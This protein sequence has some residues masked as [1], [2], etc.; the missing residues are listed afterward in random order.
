M[1]A[2]ADWRQ[3]AAARALAEAV[4]ATA[5]EA[6][7]ADFDVAV[8]AAE[9]AAEARAPQRFTIKT[10]I[11]GIDSRQ[12]PP[13]FTDAV[14]HPDVVRVV[15]AGRARL[16]F[17][18]LVGVPA[19]PVSASAMAA[20]R[21]MAAIAVRS[22]TEPALPL[23]AAVVERALLGEDWSLGGDDRRALAG[24][25]INLTDLVGALRQDHP[26]MSGSFAA[27]RLPLADLLLTASRLVEAHTSAL[28]R[29]AGAAAALSRL[30]QAVAPEVEVS[31]G[32]V[33]GFADGFDPLSTALPPRALDLRA[34][35]LVQS[36]LRARLIEHPISGRLD[37]PAAGIDAIDFEIRSVGEA[38]GAAASILIGSETSQMHSL[39]IHVAVRAHIGGIAIGHVSEFVLP[40]EVVI[41]A[42]DAEIRSIKCTGAYSDVTVAGRPARAVVSFYRDRAST[43]EA[44]SGFV[45]LIA[46]DGL[47]VWAKGSAAF[48]SDPPVVATVPATV[49]GSEMVR[50]RAPIDLGNRLAKLANE[51]AIV[52]SADAGGPPSEGG[53]RADIAAAIKDRL[54]AFED[55]FTSALAPFG[56]SPGELQVAVSAA[57]CAYAR[58]LP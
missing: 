33:F 14:E 17:G 36:V 9:R 10:S 44:A 41:D 11:G 4:A 3:V 54:G 57:S 37:S 32:A 35:D 8:Q 25:S 45:P 15:V 39:P 42:G 5:A 13:A 58:L 48:A 52:V 46:T 19:W 2:L 40:W 23:L 47:R 49:A 51:A 43:D 22:D 31:L 18:T 12:T 29:S 26:D 24:A 6:G 7:A 30:G 56:I 1:A 53:V 38:D 20:R 16:V 50:L 55:I 27:A 21:G 28:M 34:I